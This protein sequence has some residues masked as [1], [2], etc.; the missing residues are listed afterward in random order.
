MAPTFLDPRNVRFLLYE[1]LE[2]ES[3]TQYP[4]FADHDRETFDLVLQTAQKSVGVRKV[5]IP[6]STL[7]SISPVPRRFR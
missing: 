7:Q 3:L 2:V 4:Y 5:G 6:K 1:L